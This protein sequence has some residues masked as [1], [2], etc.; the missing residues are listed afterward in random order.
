MNEIFDWVLEHVSFLGFMI[1]TG[2]LSFISSVAYFIRKK[3]N[4]F[5]TVDNV[6][7]VAETMIED[8]A[9]NPDVLKSLLNKFKKSGN[10]DKAINF[11]KTFIESKIVEYEDRIITYQDKLHNGLSQDPKKAQQEINK[12]RDLIEKYSKLLGSFDED[13]A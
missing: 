13:N 4:N 2:G 11:S 5:Y 8:Y 7:A 12:Y 10:L 6:V 3:I 1:G 9:E